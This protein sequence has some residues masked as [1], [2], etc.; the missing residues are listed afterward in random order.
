MDKETLITQLQKQIV[1]YLNLEEIQ[2][3][4]IDPNESLFNEKIGLDSID[5]L[6]LIVLMQNEYEIEI[7]DPKEGREVLNSINAMADF[8][9]KEKG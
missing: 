7:E 4:E 1:E 9:I 8:I 6:E 5:A 2:P 3:G